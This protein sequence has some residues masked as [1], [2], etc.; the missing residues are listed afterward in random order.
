MPSGCVQPVASFVQHHVPVTRRIRRWR[1]LGLLI[2]ALEI[3]AIVQPCAASS[4]YH[5]QLSDMQRL[6][7]AARIHFD[8]F[9]RC[10]ITDDD[11]T[12]F[13]KLI[14]ARIIE[15]EW[16]YKTPDG[17]LPTDML[18]QPLV[19]EIQSRPDESASG[20]TESPRIWSMGPNGRDDRGLLDD[21]GPGVGPNWGYYYKRR[22]SEALITVSLTPAIVVCVW[23]LCARRSLLLC[24]CLSC[25]LTGLG[26]CITAYYLGSAGLARSTSAISPRWCDGVY[27]AGFLLTQLVA[28]PLTVLYCAI[29]LWRCLK[30]RDGSG[31]VTCSACGYDLRGLPEPRCPECGKAVIHTL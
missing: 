16:E 5:R 7:L 17:S 14:A 24:V 21:F 20:T 4:H 2:A 22:W 13:Q 9:G 27:T 31:T 6:E 29:L 15:D 11:S 30:R 25:W 26:L 19:Y 1:I 23:W 12:W 3:L 10:P 28:I 8:E 18:G